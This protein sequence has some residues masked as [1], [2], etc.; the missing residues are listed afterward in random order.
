MIRN[1]ASH[2]SLRILAYGVENSP[3]YNIRAVKWHLPLPIPTQL[4]ASFSID[5]R[6]E[7]EIPAAWWPQE[8]AGRAEEEYSTF[9]FLLIL[10]QLFIFNIHILHP[11]NLLPNNLKGLCVPAVLETPRSLAPSRGLGT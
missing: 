2:N 11:V 5:L 7:L 8:A 9:A 3:K 10:A 1:H 4:S 6:A